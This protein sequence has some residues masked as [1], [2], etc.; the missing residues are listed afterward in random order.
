MFLIAALKYM[1]AVLL[2]VQR[3][4]SVAPFAIAHTNF[5]KMEIQGYD[6]PPRT[7]ICLNTYAIHRD[8]RYWKYP[9]DGFHP[10]NFIDE[11]GN[12]EI[13]KGF[14]PF[15]VGKRLCPGEALARMNT[16]LFF[17]NVAQRFNIKREPGSTISSKQFI[18]SVA[19]I[20]IPY[21]VCFEPRY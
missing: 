15:G 10:E 18:V 17:A 6:I 7:V 2:E 4:G 9:D 14:V 12:I 8:P 20:P 11:N 13:P 21:K 3:L 19:R 16:F 1:E 5:D